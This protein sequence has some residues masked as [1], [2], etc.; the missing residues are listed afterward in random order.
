MVEV[1][2]PQGPKTAAGAKTIFPTVSGRGTPCPSQGYRVR[3]MAVVGHDCT[4]SHGRVWAF[5]L[6]SGLPMFLLVIYAQL[7]H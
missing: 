6:V 3:V 5:A 1:K 4:E 2:P 7:T